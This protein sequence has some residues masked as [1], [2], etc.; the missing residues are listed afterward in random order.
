MILRTIIEIIAVLLIIYG[1][2]HE[3]KFIAFEERIGEKIKQAF[4]K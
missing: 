4:K 2:I 3:D 1:F